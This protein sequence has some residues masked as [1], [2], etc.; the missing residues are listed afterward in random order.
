MLNKKESSIYFVLC[1]SRA[2]SLYVCCF[3]VYR[4]FLGVLVILWFDCIFMEIPTA[5]RV[6][7]GRGYIWR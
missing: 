5:I 2:L 3:K 7:G 1:L 4:F 6:Q